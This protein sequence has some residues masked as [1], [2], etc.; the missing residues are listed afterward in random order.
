LRATKHLDAAVLCASAFALLPLA[1]LSIRNVGP[2]LMLAVPATLALFDA[3]AGRD[4]ARG[5]RRPFFNLALMSAATAGV[6]LVIACAYWLQINHL[7]WTPLPPASLVALQQ[8]PDNLYNRYDEGGYLIWFAPNRRVFLD[9]R[10]DPYEPS[11][12]FEQ[13]RVETTGDYHSAFS[14]YHIRCAYLPVSS[15]VATRLAATTWTTLYRDSNWVVFADQM[16]TFERTG[17]ATTG[18]QLGSTRGQRSPE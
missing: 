11:L 16:A 18:N 1:V 4:P 9:G 3:N 2:F 5:L 6:T 8:C 12:V 13:I 14:K 17:A 15:P 7:R 10:Q